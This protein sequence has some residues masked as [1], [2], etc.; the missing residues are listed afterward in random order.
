ML[1]TAFNELEQIVASELPT[2]VSAQSRAMASGVSLVLHEDETSFEVNRT[3]VAEALNALQLTANFSYQIN[4]NE[5]NLY[6]K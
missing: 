4:N 6:K 5:I 1:T 3:N 2:D